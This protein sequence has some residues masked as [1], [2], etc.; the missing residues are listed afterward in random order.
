MGSLQTVSCWN[1]PFLRDICSFSW[2]LHSPK[3]TW[4]L[5]MDGW[6]TTL[7]GPFSGGFYC[8][9]QSNLKPL[10]RLAILYWTHDPAKMLIC[11]LMMQM[12][13]AR[14]CWWIQPRIVNLAPE[15][16]RSVKEVFQPSFLYSCLVK[17]LGLDTPRKINMEPENDGLEDDFP[18]QLGDF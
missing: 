6:E 10:E 13:G 18:F 12:K 11:Y 5:K 15:I 8:S 17:F 3:L 14:F 9:F 16:F 2:R 7:K 4:H 1:G